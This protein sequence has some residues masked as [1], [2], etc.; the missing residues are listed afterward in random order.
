MKSSNGGLELAH[1]KEFKMKCVYN[2]LS[3][4]IS[5]KVEGSERLAVVTWGLAVLE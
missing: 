2:Q 4:F 5:R 3:S 1:R